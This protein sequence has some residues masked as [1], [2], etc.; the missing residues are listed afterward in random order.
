MPNSNELREERKKARR[1]ALALAIVS[2]RQ[3]ARMTQG[4]VADLL[5]WSRTTLVAIESARQATSVDQLYE[6]ADL[7]DYDVNDFLQYD[8]QIE[9]TKLAGGFF[10]PD[11]YKS[12][13]PRKKRTPEKA[14]DPM[15][16]CA[17]CHLPLD[18]YDYPYEVCNGC[19][20]QLD[21][22]AELNAELQPAAEPAAI[23]EASTSPATASSP[24]PT[25]RSS[26]RAKPAARSSSRAKPAA[27]SSSRAKPAA[28]S[29]SPAEDPD[30]VTFRTR[31]S[32]KKKQ[33]AKKAKK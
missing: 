11:H 22:A 5:G 3:S 21:R 26:T 12:Q 30:S 1:V 27:R 4:Q 25:T 31:A 6:L 19:R 14:A 2:K 13:L 16:E 23:L 8:L 29:K 18:D 7:L 32:N 33:T 20:Q 10:P 15:P 24:K 9:A 28:R 17:I